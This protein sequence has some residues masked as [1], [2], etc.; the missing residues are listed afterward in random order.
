MTTS[1][2]VVDIFAGCGGLG[3]GFSQKRPDGRLPFDVKLSIENEIAPIRTLQLRSFFHQF[4]STEVPEDYYQYVRGEIDRGELFARYPRESRAALERCLQA[5]LGN[6]DFEQKVHDSIASTI[7]GRRDWV[8][9][10]G[11][12]CQAY[13]VAGRSRNQSIPT[14]DPDS[15]GRFEL[16]REYLK[17][18]TDHWP[19]V[20]VMENVKGLLSASYRNR[21]IF[22]RMKEDLRE[23]MRAFPKLRRRRDGDYRYRLYSLATRVPLLGDLDESPNPTDFVIKS[24]RFG[25]PQA[26][27]RV[28]LVG[29]R[30]DISAIPEPLWPNPKHVDAAKVLDGVPRLRS[31]LSRRDTPEGWLKAVKAICGQPWWNQIKP[32]LRS[33]VQEAVNEVEV[34]PHGRGAHRFLSAESDCD[35]MSEWFLDRRLKG[36]LNH[37][38]RGH[39]EDDL[40]RYT[41]AA[42]AQRV[43]IQPFRLR[44]FPPGLRPNHKNL[45]SSLAGESFSDRF[46]VQRKVGP[47]RTV[48]SHIRKD[49][50]YYIHYDATQCRSLT[51][52]EA[53]RLQTFPDN[54]FFEG[55]QTDQYGQVGNAVPP[56]LSYQI[57]DR[58]AELLRQTAKEAHGHNLG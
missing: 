58:I 24:E 51:V 34:P 45:E 43:S 55:N 32:S 44:D 12:P 52:R 30:D 20:F 13:S 38:A 37:W 3:E 42:C 36:T 22:G 14:Y 26:R 29:V 17:I 10:G 28:V 19:A 40:W 39:R 41:F 49:G 2:P 53:A 31:G 15:D 5:E 9:I 21:L 8:L 57:A 33:L 46:S 6:P 18:I 23:P 1:I 47:S 16:Y 56:L 11:P 50:H 4:R 48:V 25:I 35:F 54:F 7:S 27:H